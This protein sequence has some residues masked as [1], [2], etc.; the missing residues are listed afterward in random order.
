LIDHSANESES[1]SPTPPARFEVRETWLDRI[2]VLSVRH[3]VDMLTAPQLT[4]AIHD[5]FS[6]TPAALIVDLS[7]VQFLASAGMTVLVAAREEAG[8]ST[9]FAV[10]ADGPATSRP[11]KVL[12]LDN[13]LA[14]YPT[15]DGALRGVG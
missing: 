13:F 9:R 6:R 11:M 10:V 15:L 8:Q 1:V 14:L 4:E 3:E 7:G 12:G 2:A 5:A